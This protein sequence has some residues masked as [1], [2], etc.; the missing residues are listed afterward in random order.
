MVLKVYSTRDLTYE[1]AN[2]EKDTTASST[3]VVPLFPVGEYAAQGH[4]NP[5][6]KRLVLG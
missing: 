5:L 6:P 2:P 3:R 4:S 1:T